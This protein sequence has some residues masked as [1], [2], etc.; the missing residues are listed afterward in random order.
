MVV[1]VAGFLHVGG[2]VGVGTYGFFW[3][4]SAVRS[5]RW[6]VVVVDGR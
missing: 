2:E 5:G 3:V 6:R 1:W 4:N